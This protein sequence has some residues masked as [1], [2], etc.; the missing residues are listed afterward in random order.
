MIN[1]SENTNQQLQSELME[2]L[3]QYERDKKDFEVK[4]KKWVDDFNKKYK[5]K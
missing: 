1:K 3:S 2:A 5:N 4:K